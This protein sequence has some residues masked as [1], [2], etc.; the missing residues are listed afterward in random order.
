[1]NPLVAVVGA[2]GAFGYGGCL[3]VAGLSLPQWLCIV[4]DRH[5]REASLQSDSADSDSD[6]SGCGCDL[7]GEHARLSGAA[8]EEGK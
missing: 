6:C 2:V 1:M 5:G 8:N 3:W 4:G 7:T